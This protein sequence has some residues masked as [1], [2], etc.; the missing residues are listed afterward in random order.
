LG[1]GVLPGTPEDNVRFFF[2]TAKQADKL[3]AVAA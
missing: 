3:L 2:E 1:H